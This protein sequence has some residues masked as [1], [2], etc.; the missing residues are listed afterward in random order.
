MSFEQLEYNLEEQII[1]KLD[2]IYV[3]NRSEKSISNLIS[4][5]N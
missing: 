3:I 4:C 5:P 1:S 2:A